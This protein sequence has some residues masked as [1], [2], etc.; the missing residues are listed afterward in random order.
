[1]SR[2]IITS[3]W[4]FGVISLALCLVNPAAAQV[5]QQ[6]AEAYFKEAA[7]ICQRDGGRLW[8]VSLCGPMVFADART[9]TLATNQ[10]RPAGEWPRVLGFTNAPIEW[11][12]SRWA[13]YMWDFTTS[14]PDARTRGMFMLHELFHRIQPD[15][16]LIAAGGPAR[17]GNAHLDTVEGRVWLR[18]EWRALA[19]AL[20]QSGESRKR[21]VSDAAAFRWMRRSQ[22]AN[23]AENERVEE[24][25]EGLAQ[26]TGT[27]AAATS[28]PEAVASALEQLAAAEQH[29]TFLQQAYTTGVAYGVLLDDASPDWRRSVRSNSD[30][31]QMLMVALE[32]RPAAD[33]VKASARYG[34]AEIRAAEKTRDEQHKA[35]ILELRNRFV[36]GP[37]LLVPSGGGA[38]FNAVGATPI[39]GAGTVY[40]MPYRTSSEWGTLEAMK[41]VLINE[42]GTRRLPGPIR[43]EGSTLTGDGWTVTVAPGWRVRPGPRSG[44]YQI[45]RDPQ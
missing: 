14:L 37:G 7:T 39:P 2:D 31:G 16:G 40:V 29:E 11:G 12:G 42:D 15:L 8:G 25:G 41:G 18:L 43:I 36:A 24:I 3:A 1:M 35:R 5:D 34:G 21:A 38:S 33:A 23:A 6:R 28:H 13:A 20:A 22:F 4:W 27:V 32:I 26:Y 10:P 45:I 17:S 30:L 19:Q 9:R 44:D